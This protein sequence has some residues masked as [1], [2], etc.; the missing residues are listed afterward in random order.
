MHSNALGMLNGVFVDTLCFYYRLH[1][2]PREE[3][4]A[5]GDVRE[6]AAAPGGLALPGAVFDWSQAKLLHDAVTRGW[7]VGREQDREQARSLR[8]RVEHRIEPLALLG[9]ARQPP[10]LVLLDVLVGAL[11]KVPGNP[12]RAA[13]IP[14]FQRGGG[15][16][17]RLLRD[18]LQ[19]RFQFAGRPRRGDRAAAIAP[20]HRDHAIEQVAEVVAKLLI[21]V[22]HQAGAREI[23]VGG[24][25]EVA[26]EIVAHG[27]GPD[28]IDERDRIDDVAAALGYALALQ[29]DE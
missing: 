10:R 2:H 19:I 28:F 14:A 25:R 29:C 21:V 18:A 12:Q 5:G 4:S 23:A 22:A 8:C 16:L 7:D 3:H 1:F 9:L 26:H 17:A 24:E 15:L 6:R 27:I 20:D 11:H 13:D